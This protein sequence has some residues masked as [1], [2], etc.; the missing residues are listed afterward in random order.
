MKNV[1]VIKAAEFF[2]IHPSVLLLPS[3]MGRDELE[4][5]SAVMKLIDER[6]KHP[7][8]MKPHVEI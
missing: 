5:F 7:K 6:R 4:I 3:E 8:R 2:R 1:V